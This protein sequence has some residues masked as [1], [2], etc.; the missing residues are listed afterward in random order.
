MTLKTFSLD[1]SLN[2]PVPEF[3]FLL[4]RDLTVPKSV[5]TGM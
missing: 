3:F 2:E 5:L 1:V 4:A